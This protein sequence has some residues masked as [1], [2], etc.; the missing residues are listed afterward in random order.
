METEKIRYVLGQKEVDQIT[1]Y[2]SIARANKSVLR[3]GELI[4]LMSIEATEEDLEMAWLE[5]E[6]LSSTFLLR[7]GYIVERTKMRS[8]SIREEEVNRDRARKNLSVASEFADVCVD[9]HVKLFAVSGGNSYQRAREGDDIDFFCVTTRDSLWIFMLRTLI[10]A[11]LYRMTRRSPQFC[12]SY[13]MDERMVQSS[14]GDARD[15]LFARDALSAH[16]LSGEHFYR[17]LLEG[18]DW[19]ESYFP[20]MYRY[21][22]SNAE[23]AVDR[24]FTK[25]G[26]RALNSF[27][28]YTV[29]TYVRVKAFLANERYRK[30]K[31]VPAIFRVRI[32]RDHCIY[33]SNRYKWLRRV[34]NTP[35]TLG[36]GGISE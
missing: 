11:R 20:R 31:N 34:Y 23:G 14:F 35:A 32:D 33:E 22:I 1:V 6:F 26:S 5:N 21:K 18:A 9:N 28:Y 3:L 7:S 24:P 25:R 27:L 36:T 4:Q 8:D 19:M 10:L 29:G 2:C 17:S 13:V 12:F 15:G 16:V 30:K